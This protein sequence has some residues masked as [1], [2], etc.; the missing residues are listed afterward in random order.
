MKL[1]KGEDGSYDFSLLP[2]DDYIHYYIGHHISFVDRSCI[3]DGIS[4]DDIYFDLSFIEKKLQNNP[5]DLLWDYKQYKVFFQNVSEMFITH[6]SLDSYM[7]R[8]TRI[9]KLSE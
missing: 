1:C 3:I 6:Q 9:Q 2:D 5:K 8:F 7:S 4:I